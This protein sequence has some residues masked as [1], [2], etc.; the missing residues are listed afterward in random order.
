MIEFDFSFRTSRGEYK[1]TFVT[2]A[3][4]YIYFE[5]K[6]I[7]QATANMPQHAT[8]MM[9][10]QLIM[11]SEVGEDIKNKFCHGEIEVN[12]LMEEWIAVNR[13]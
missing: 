6:L 13:K 8:P 7:I 2:K 10:V 3:V 1:V 5:D 11:Q 4:M 9:A 12:D